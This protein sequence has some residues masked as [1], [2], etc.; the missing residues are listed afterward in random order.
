MKGPIGFQ[1]S[2]FFARHNVRSDACHPRS[3]TSL[4]SVYPNTHESAFASD[5]LRACLPMTATSSPSYCTGPGE[6]AGM[7]IDSSVGISAL[8]ER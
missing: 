1:V 5:S 7:T 8:L 4:P 6:S 3:L 2:Q